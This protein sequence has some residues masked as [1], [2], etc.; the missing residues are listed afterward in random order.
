MIKVEEALVK[1]AQ[2]EIRALTVNG[3]Q[4][5]QALFRQLQQ[6][7][8]WNATFDLTGPLW[9]WINYHSGCV[10]AWTHKHVIWQQGQELRKAQV[11]DEMPGLLQWRAFVKEDAPALV[12]G[13]KDFSTQGYADFEAKVATERQKRKDEMA[14]AEKQWA[15]FRARH[16]TD[17]PQ[18]FIAV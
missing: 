3:R 16:I 17:L 6:E 7:D 1:T 10:A 13:W 18:L 4:V 5:T 12:P 2:V 15:E 11:P 9:G 8:C 14:Q